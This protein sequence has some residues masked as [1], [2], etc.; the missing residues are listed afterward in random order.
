MLSPRAA[1]AI[2]QRN[3][4]WCSTGISDATWPQYSNSSPASSIAGRRSRRMRAQPGEHRQLLAAHEHVDGVD[5]DRDPRA[6]RTA[7][8]DGD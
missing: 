7:G 2:F 1:A 4:G 6:R 3:S 8:R 5:L